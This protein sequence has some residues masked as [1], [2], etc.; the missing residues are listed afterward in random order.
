MRDYFTA[1]DIP[2]EDEEEPEPVVA[3]KPARPRRERGSG[4]PSASWSQGTPAPT[5]SRAGS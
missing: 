1:A 5:S 3:V 2:E 4:R